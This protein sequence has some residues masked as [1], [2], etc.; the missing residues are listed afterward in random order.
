MLDESGQWI[1]DDADRLAQLQALV[2]EAAIKGQGRIWIFVTTHEDMGA[3]YQNA[4]ALQADMKKI[5]G[6]FRYKWSLTTENIELVLEDRIFKKK[7]AGK[8]AVEIGR[9]SCRERV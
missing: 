7:I 9:A 5:E 1:E 4:R 3:I 8:D 2:E 6:R